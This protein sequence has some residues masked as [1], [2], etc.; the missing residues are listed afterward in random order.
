MAFWGSSLPSSAILNSNSDVRDPWFNSGLTKRK[1]ADV[2]SK[3]TQFRTDLAKIPSAFENNQ[4]TFSKV[5]VDVKL[6]VDRL[7]LLELGLNSTFNVLYETKVDGQ[8]NM[9]S[10]ENR[11]KSD[12][13]S[14]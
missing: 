14:N 3:L 8:E 13:S 1:L 4:E 5:L 9:A 12:A 11:S 7:K 6:A 10:P 2:I